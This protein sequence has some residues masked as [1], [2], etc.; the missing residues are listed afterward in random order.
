M[1][2][3]RGM[4]FQIDRDAVA[5]CFAQPEIDGSFHGVFADYLA[6]ISRLRPVLLFA[7]PPKAAGTFL[8]RAAAVAADGSLV[9][10]VHA[11]GG[12]EAQFYLPVFVSYF[13][14]GVCDGPMTIHAHM[15]ARPGNRGFVEALSLKPIVMVRPVCDMLA[16]LWDMLAANREAR[17]ENISGAVPEDFPA[18][19]AARKADYLIDMIGPWYVNYYA[20]WLEYAEARPESVLVLRYDAFRR[21]PLETLERVLRHAGLAPP[22]EAVEAALAG[23]WKER[24][25]VR[26]NKGVPGRGGD[27]FSPEH[28]ARLVRMMSNYPVLAPWRGALL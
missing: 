13:N 20:T 21:D 2:T 22:R 3:M 9:R 11:Q 18:F 4:G 28:V 1:Q 15:T 14:G 25:K 12:R 6:R 5:A 27:Y 7:F 19:A 24:D 16:S 26:F 10:A 17:L 23:V 8:S